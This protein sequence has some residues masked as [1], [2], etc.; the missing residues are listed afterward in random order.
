MTTSYLF[1]YSK[2]DSQVSISSCMSIKTAF[3]FLSDF[4]LYHTPISG[5][6]DHHCIMENFE[7]VGRK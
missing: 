6:I 3:F 5:I 2:L 1:A 7:D 4:L